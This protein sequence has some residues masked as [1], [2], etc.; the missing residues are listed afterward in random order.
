MTD[1]DNSKEFGIITA[2]DDAVKLAMQY[3]WEQ[4]RFLNE[5]KY[6]WQDEVFNQEC[7]ERTEKMFEREN[8]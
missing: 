3:G 4:D 6:C 2:I 7:D 1:F 5:V 8:A